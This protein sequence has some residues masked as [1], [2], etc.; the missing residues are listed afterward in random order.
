MA[1]V[2]AASIG[3]MYAV[4]FTVRAVAAR[5][6]MPE[7]TRSMADTVIVR[8]GVL[9]ALILALVFAE[10]QS[11]FTELRG[12]VA[13]EATTVLSAYYDME[14]YG[15]DETQVP[16]RALVAY[17][18]HVVDEEWEMLGQGELSAH[19]W[20]DWATALDAVLDLDAQ[21]PR[22]IDLR[23]EVLT[24]LQAIAELRELRRIGATK[25]IHS[26]FWMVAIGGFLLIAV[27]YHV[28]RPSKQNLML[29]GTYALFNGIM[30]YV[31]ATTSNPYDG[32]A[33]VEPAHFQRLLDVEF[34]AHI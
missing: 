31:I 6:D 11:D 29:L 27:P 34:P 30:F 20:A 15:P 28:Y 21:T 32:V 23:R 3:A 4:Y 17:V 19:A 9:H 16:R 14:R 26:M 24:G 13:L 7:Q 5:P 2:S 1:A 8:I 33:A 25:N 22:Q 10:G 18:Q 12:N